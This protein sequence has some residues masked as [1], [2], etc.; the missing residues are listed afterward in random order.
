M[1]QQTTPKP[2]LIDRLNELLKGLGELWNPP[3]PA[4][5][6]VPVRERPTR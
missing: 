5:Q 3:T 6:P 2:T 4:P 1:S